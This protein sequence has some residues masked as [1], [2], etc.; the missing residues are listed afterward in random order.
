[1][2]FGEA[3]RVSLADG[4][5][6]E[7]RRTASGWHVDLLAGG[8]RSSIDL[9]STIVPSDE[10]TARVDRSEPPPLVLDRAGRPLLVRLGEEHYRRS[11][12]SWRDAGEPRAE[13]T[14]T[15]SDGA[16]DIGVEVAASDLTFA[17]A[18]AVNPFDNEHADVNG[19]S[20][21]LYLRTSQGLS[22]WMLVPEP[23][24][25]HVR[26]RQLEGWSAEQPLGATWQRWGSGYRMS[27]TVPS[28][29]PPLA[30]DVIINEMPRS[31]T[32]RRGQL[33]L[34]DARGEFV[35]LRGDRHEADRLIPLRISDG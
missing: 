30:I 12:Q 7:H 10:P 4:T 13:V 31:R 24:D 26:T 11:E 3:I 32:R 6:H 29:T 8:A 19:D 22:A 5:V 9:A 1:V 15:W 17:A 2:E 25:H 21:Q 20:V 16:L 14:L 28:P 34:S 27:I 33:V 35:Y 23:S 18:T